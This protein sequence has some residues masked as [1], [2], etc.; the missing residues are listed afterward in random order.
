MDWGEV[1]LASKLGWVAHVGRISASLGVAFFIGCSMTRNDPLDSGEAFQMKVAAPAP[2][3]QS[4][5]EAP[6]TT[7]ENFKPA[8]TQIVGPP[9]P[10]S[11]T[12]E[13]TPATRTSRVVFT[14]LA[15]PPRAEAFGK[16]ADTLI[17]SLD[18]E[19][20]PLDTKSVFADQAP[21]KRYKAKALKEGKSASQETGGERYRALARE[22]AEKEAKTLLAQV[23]S[24]V[25]KGSER[26]PHSDPA[27][28]AN[29]ANDSPEESQASSE[30]EAAGSK[31]PW[32]LA[33]ATS[34]KVADSTDHPSL[35]SLASL[36]KSRDEY[37][38]AATPSNV[39]QFE[40][41]RSW[42]TSKEVPAAPTSPELDPWNVIRDQEFP[43]VEHIERK[44][45]LEEE[46][47]GNYR[48]AP[49]DSVDVTVWEMPDLSRALF[50]RPDGYISFPLIREVKAAGKTPSQLQKTLEE[51]LSEEL[52][53][54]KV[55]VVVTSVG[56]KAYY[57]FGAVANPGVFQ[58][59]RQT[60]LLQ[61]IV[62]AG[63]FHSVLRAG[64]PVPHGDMAR[65][66]IIRT[67]DAGREIVTKNLKDLN[68]QEMLGED[69]PIQPDDIIY[70]PQEAQLVYV[71]GEVLAP[72]VVPIHDDTRM[73]EAL[74]GAGGVRPTGKRNQIL[75]IRPSKNG[76]LPCYA[77]TSL[78]AIE[79][80]NLAANLPVQSGDIIVVPQKFIAK[81]A[82][83]VQLYTSAIQP[84]LETY[85]TSWDAWF[86]HERFS[87][88]R[89]SNFGLLGGNSTSQ[90]PPN[91]DP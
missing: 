80:G 64:Q 27:S 22:A 31:D 66:R 32:G 23:E 85:L 65:V 74:L 62:A 67:T 26:A 17:A 15:E 76:G 46:P 4:K 50:V 10:G 13:A 7:Q 51:H 30:G 70:V 52:I 38:T 82:E 58:F 3:G 20:G 78:K 21:A 73:L 69:I 25:I 24:P 36:A 53:E 18:S 86:V 60:T 47:E 9:L 79:Q 68:K 16:I 1:E 57:V 44:Q 2:P 89:R 39:S 40:A 77:C 61:S 75:L 34:P 12:A 49:G 88:L 43:P 81:V 41:G 45:L 48:L 71:F 55:N 19:K 91:A 72:G 63:G 83:F 28:P 37:Q 84:A 42:G 59:F 14:G 29:R 35:A 90:V 6:K 56:S 87:A 33:G 8:L 11:R 5:V 54:P